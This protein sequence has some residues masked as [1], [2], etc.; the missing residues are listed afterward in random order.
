[1]W[2]DTHMRKITVFIILALQ[3]CATKIPVQQVKVGH[4]INRNQYEAFGSK[5]IIASQGP[6]ATRAAKKILDMGGNVF[7]AAIATSFVISVARPQS[8]GIGGGGF[9]LLYN[10]KEKKTYAVDFRELAPLK[11]NE[12]MFQ[13]EKE[14]VIPKK[15]SEGIFAAGV[16]TLVA[17]MESIHQKFGKLSWDVVIQPAIDI[18]ENGFEIYPELAEAMK[19]QSDVLGQSN[20]AKSIFFGVDGT[21]KKL[22]EQ[23]VQKDL[24]KTL[25][26]IQSKGA[27]GFYEGWVRDA[28]LETNRRHQGLMIKEDFEQDFVKYRE[29]IKGVF[30][31]F[32]VVSMPPPSS[33]GTHVIEILNIVDPIDIW[34]FHDPMNPT[35]VHYVSAAMQAAFADRFK[36]MGDPDF[37]DVPVKMLTSLQHGK[38]IRKKFWFKNKAIP[39]KVY[40]D[41]IDSKSEPTETTHFS[42][43]GGNGDVVASTQTINGWFGSN[44]VVE[45]TG[46][47]LNNEMDDFAAKVGASDNFGLIGGKSN[48]IAPK[49]R[50]LSSMSPTIV[51]DWKK[52]P[53]LALGTPNGSRIISCVVQVILNYIEFRM[54]LYDAVT[55]M[56]YHHQW[57]PEEIRVESPGFPE[58]TK[59]SLEA[60]GYKI[61]QQDYGC[62]VQAVAREGEKLHGVSDVR[63]NGLALGD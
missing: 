1:M 55:A 63:G 13:D 33:G 25:R 10:A 20:Y 53:V 54:P 41:I 40:A 17:G 62:R 15:S 51:F 58:K 26:E 31:N 27:K 35:A 56:R 9:M 36:Y 22:G 24:A 46:I 57:Y 42:I 52:R 18:A 37:V 49:K 5:Y 8:T 48:A 44:V 45:G 7:D 4:P 23:L 6:E 32:D 11:A 61:N 59:Q 50:P 29:P 38:E 21:P 30:A 39:S 43:M 47:V 3:A 34:K 19:G 14:N 2:H 12:K 28:I 60:M 16:P